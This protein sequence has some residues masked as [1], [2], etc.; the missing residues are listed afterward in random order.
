MM[1]NK[2]IRKS[3][4]SFCCYRPVNNNRYRIIW[5]ITNKCNLKCKHCFVDCSNK[6]DE[7]STEE[8]INLIRDFSNFPVAKV[9]LTGGEPFMRKDI[10]KIIQTIKSIDNQ[11]IVDVTTNMTLLN[12]DKINQIKEL[13]IEELTT[14]ID[15]NPEIHDLIRGI[16]GNFKKIISTLKFVRERDIDVDVVCV[17]NKLNKDKISEI[18]DIAYHEGFSSLTV[19]GLIIRED[20]NNS[21]HQYALTVDETNS[22]LKKIQLKREQYGNLFP[23]RT[24]ALKNRFSGQKCTINNLIS[25]SY[26][27]NIYKCL[28]TSNK[29][30]ETFN[31]RTH[32]LSEVYKNLKNVDCYLRS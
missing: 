21:I 2:S 16:N 32:K 18:I 28:L 17:V 7:L 11:I 6:N 30:P 13:G 8:C 14:S 25:V 31:V 27:G 24:V 9:M 12:E 19:S 22:I 15:G 26:N 4:D 1:T 23:I 10:L 3:D 5:E 20:T 29:S